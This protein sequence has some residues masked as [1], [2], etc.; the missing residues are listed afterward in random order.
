MAPE[1]TFGG[2]D[3]AGRAVAAPDQR[4]RTRPA[5]RPVAFGGLML[6]TFVLFVAP[7][8]FVPGA[9]SA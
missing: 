8:N 6:F 7:Q 2:D 1:L 3:V 5:R 9:T 4:A